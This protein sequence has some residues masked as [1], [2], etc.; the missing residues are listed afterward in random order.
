[1]SISYTHG[2]YA[3]YNQCRKR[4]GG[5]CD[6]CRKAA[7]EYQTKWRKLNAEKQKRLDEKQNIRNKAIRI[8]VKRYPAE[9][10]KIINQLE[11][12]E[13]KRCG[14]IARTIKRTL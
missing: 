7:S 2:T 3:G 1:M 8:L 6:K 14:E 10:R 13:V 11:S 5:V 12:E 9:L 4:Q